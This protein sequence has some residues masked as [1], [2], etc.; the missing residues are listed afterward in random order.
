MIS[1][2]PLMSDALRLIRLTS[3]AI[4]IGGIPVKDDSVRVENMVVLKQRREDR[5]RHSEGES[6]ME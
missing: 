2:R 6:G 5:R 1:F 4:C 3:T